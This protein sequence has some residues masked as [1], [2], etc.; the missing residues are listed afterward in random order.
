MKNDT[1]AKIV[2]PASAPSAALAPFA[3][4]WER[5]HTYAA[6]P[7]SAASRTIAGVR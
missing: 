5:P 1:A 4:A 3:P 2:S 7:N 6:T